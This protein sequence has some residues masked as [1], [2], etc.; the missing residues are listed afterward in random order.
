MRLFW[1]FDEPSRI[2]LCRFLTHLAHPIGYNL[3]H[4]GHLQGIFG[5]GL[6]ARNLDVVLDPNGWKGDQKKRTEFAVRI[7][8]CSHMLWMF[9][10]ASLNAWTLPYIFLS[11]CLSHAWILSLLLWPPP[12]AS[13][14]CSNVPISIVFFNSSFPASLIRC[15]GIWWYRALIYKTIVLYY[16]L[17]T[18]LCHRI[19]ISSYAPVRLHSLDKSSKTW[20]G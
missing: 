4:F 1:P 13:R 8:G 3:E 9:R 15:Y 20:A 14:C 2:S 17:A 12:S 11:V 19:A 6:K 10:F 5:A 18:P 7:A 16:L